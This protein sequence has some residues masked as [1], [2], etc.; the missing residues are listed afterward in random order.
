MMSHAIPKFSVVPSPQYCGGVKGARPKG[1]VK[2]VFMDRDDP[3]PVLLSIRTLPIYLPFQ[4]LT[5]IS[6]TFSQKMLPQMWQRSDSP[7]NWRTI[8]LNFPE[9][10]HKIVPQI[11]R[12]LSQI[13]GDNFYKDSPINCRFPINYTTNR[14]QNCRSRASYTDKSRINLG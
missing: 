10:A 2:G 9:F 8:Q 13:P 14:P 12:R 3:A 6:Q 11:L 4:G 1:A 5:N 7:T